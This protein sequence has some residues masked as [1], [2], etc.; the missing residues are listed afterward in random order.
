MELRNFYVIILGVISVLGLIV[1]CFV[2]FKYGKEYKGGKKIADNSYIEDDAYFKKKLR[3]YKIYKILTTVF[4]IFAV[5]VCFFMMAGPYKI[6]EEDK[7]V[8]NRDIVLCLDVSSSVD[9]VNMSLVSQLKETVSNLKGERFGIVIFNTSPV[10][11]IPLTSDYEFVIKQLDL[12]E[13]SLESR[14]TIEV[15]DDNF[16]ERMYMQDY[17]MEG[18]ITDSDERGSSMIGDGLA[19]STYVFEEDE[20]DE[21][22]TK[23]II[24]S[25]DNDLAGEPIFTLDE[26][27]GICKDKNI[28]VFGIGTEWMNRD[29]MSEMQAAMTKT[30]GKFYLEE[31]AGSFEKIVNDIEK[32]SKS[33]M[34]DETEIKKIELVQVPFIILLVSVSVMLILLKVTK[35]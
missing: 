25:T 35:R 8:Y 29:D 27:A 9:E 5:A 20:E 17:I 19:A 23:I 16:Y 34:K 24:F 3:R 6:K 11:L 12:I 7:N 28:T 2:N 4:C 13:S 22:R 32:T 15:Y 33:L 10:T 18:T 1:L 14:S 21:E 31:E 30:G 26:A